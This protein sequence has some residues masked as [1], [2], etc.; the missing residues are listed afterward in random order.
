MIEIL[1]T[2]LDK[3]NA[4]NASALDINEALMDLV[5]VNRLAKHNVVQLKAIFSV[6]KVELEQFLNGSVFLESMKGNLPS[7]KQDLVEVH[8]S[9]LTS[10]I[11]EIKDQ[12]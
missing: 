1:R 5:C 7:V 10:N 3:A 9:F 2:S 6:L 12:I 11:H 8:T 4:P